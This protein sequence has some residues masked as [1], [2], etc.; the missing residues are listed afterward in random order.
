[1]NFLKTLLIAITLMG[2]SMGGGI[3]RIRGSA[4]EVPNKGKA[5]ELYLYFSLDNKLSKDSFLVITTPASFAFAIN[6]IS[7][8]DIS[9]GL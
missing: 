5:S 8:A 6:D 4:W 7:F 3:H 2:L 1:M 9:A